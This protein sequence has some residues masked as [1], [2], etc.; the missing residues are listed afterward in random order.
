MG[1]V[2]HGIPRK[3]ALEL[4][5]KHGLKAFVETGSY[6]GGTLFWASLHFEKAIG[7]EISR[8][9]YKFAKRAC[10]DAKNVVL[11]RGDSRTELSRALSLAKS[12]ALVWL[13]AHWST[14]L[15]SSKP[16][17]GEC[18]LLDE[19]GALNADGRPH[20]VLI[21]DARLFDPPLNEEWPGIGEV[22]TL[23]EKRPR[24]VRI[25]EDV[26]IAEPKEAVEVWIP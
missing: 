13:D 5:D 22:F 14:D 7:I 1:N 24:T 18:P 9:Y 10:G 26:I 6:V 21:D 11:I 20:V 16:G 3:L 23:L 4:R 25:F 12:P 15:E 2:H 17:M 8:F 19:L